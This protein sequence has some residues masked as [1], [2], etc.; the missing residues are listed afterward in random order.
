M[1]LC[2]LGQVPFML[3][4]L[5]SVVDWL[6]HDPGLL[7]LM[8]LIPHCWVQPVLSHLGP[9]VPVSFGTAYRNQVIL[10]DMLSM[11]SHL[12]FVIL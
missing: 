9:P 5:L 3:V 8:Y 1:L 12:D 10:G 6:S 4:N 11:R 7:H 2:Y